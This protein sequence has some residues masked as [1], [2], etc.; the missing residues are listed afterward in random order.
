MQNFCETISFDEQSQRLAI[1]IEPSDQYL[2]I[3]CFIRYCSTL[4]IA[5]MVLDELHEAVAA[6]QSW[7]GH[8]NDVFA[9]YDPNQQRITAMYERSDEVIAPPSTIPVA[10]FLRLL[11][12]WRDQLN[13]AG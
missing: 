2:F 4:S 6:G 3:E 7:T 13:A 8:C 10:D 5:Q 12:K 1:R 11:T 9:R